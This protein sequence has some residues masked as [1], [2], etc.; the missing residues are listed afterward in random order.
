MFYRAGKAHDLVEEITYMDDVLNAFF[1]DI[2][3][4]FLLLK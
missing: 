4:A 2:A 1:I 3:F